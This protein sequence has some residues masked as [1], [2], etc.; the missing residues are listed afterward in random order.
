[1]N[2][3]LFISLTKKRHHRLTSFHSQDD[4]YPI[5]FSGQIQNKS[6]KNIY[7]VG[8]DLK[9][10]AHD[11]KENKKE[12]KN[13]KILLAKSLNIG[14]YLITPLLVGVFSGYWLDKVFRTKPMFLLLFFGL[15]VIGSFYN[16]WKTVQEN[17]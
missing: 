12:N 13:E 3:D 1:M 7:Q 14:Y 15:G 9:I 16:L 11:I 6:K 5:V 8:H 17:I 2:N 10:K 4:D